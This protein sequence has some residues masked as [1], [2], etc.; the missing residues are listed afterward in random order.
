MSMEFHTLKRE[1]WIP[2]SIQ[3]VFAFFADAHNLEQITPRWLNFKIQSS[4]IWHPGS[5]NDCLDE[6]NGSGLARSEL[7]R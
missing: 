5:R 2:R 3:E 6:R 7:T 4:R 1:Q